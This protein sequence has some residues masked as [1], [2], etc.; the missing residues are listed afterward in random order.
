MN[1]T[2]SHLNLVAKTCG[3]KDNGQKVSYMF[4]EESHS[5]CLDKKDLL[6]AEIQACELLLGHTRDTSERKTVEKELAEL[7]MALDLLT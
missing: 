6:A 2:H 4:L 7:K 1:I 3:C 5:L